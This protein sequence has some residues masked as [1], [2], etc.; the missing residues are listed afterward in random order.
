MTPCFQVVVS[1]PFPPILSNRTYQD[2]QDSNIGYTSSS[3]C[4]TTDR[5]PKEP[6][7]P[8]GTVEAIPR[9]PTS[10]RHRLSRLSNI[11]ISTMTAAGRR[12][13]SNKAR[14][15][16]LHR[17]TGCTEEVSVLGMFLSSMMAFPDSPP[18]ADI[19][20]NRIP[21]ISHDRPPA[22]RLA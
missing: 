15:A 3:R 11:S 19:H 20:V 16:G 21:L 17:Y 2:R 13:R 8:T 7:Q 14:Q 12:R 6:A 9:F 5:A 1:R 10:N 4:D 22:L 18:A